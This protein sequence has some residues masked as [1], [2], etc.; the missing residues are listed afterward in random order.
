MIIKQKIINNIIMKVNGLPNLGNTCYFNSTI[1]S[2]V[3]NKNIVNLLLSVKDEFELKEFIKNYHQGNINMNLLFKMINKI[4]PTFRIT[5]QQD[6]SEL[7]IM[8]LDII[9]KNTNKLMFEGYFMINIKQG[10]ICTE[11]KNVSNS[12]SKNNLLLLPVKDTLEESFISFEELDFLKEDNKYHCDKCNEKTN[13]IK[14]N[15]IDLENLPINFGIV[16]KRFDNFRKDNRKIKVP[17]NIKNRKLKSII[18]HY[19]SLNGGHYINITRMN[20][21]WI[22]LNDNHCEIIDEDKAINMIQ[23]GYIFWYSI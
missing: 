3:L 19:G 14:K 22:L 16:I 5:R 1:Q 17:L 23:D 15:K 10:I 7:L 13:A 11:C 21:L 4:N 20:N 18:I 12:S 9:E 6:A 2:L 8:L